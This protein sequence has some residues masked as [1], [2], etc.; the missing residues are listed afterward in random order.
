M[1]VYASKGIECNKEAQYKIARAE[2]CGGCWGDCSGLSLY[3]LSL[4]EYS[5]MRISFVV[6]QNLRYVFKKPKDE[7]EFNWSLRIL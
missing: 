1:Y 5:T 3:I 6:K 2:N 7:S 4:F